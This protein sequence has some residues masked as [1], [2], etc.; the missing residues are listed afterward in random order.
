MTDSFVSNV[1][2][3]SYVSNVYMSCLVSNVYMSI[4]N[5]RCVYELQTSGMMRNAFVSN[6]ENVIDH[7]E[8]LNQ[9]MEERF[10]AALAEVID[11]CSMGDDFQFHFFSKKT[12]GRNARKLLLSQGFKLL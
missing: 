8:I 10:D 7:K 6:C 2:M 3:S 4:V 5:I 12:S 1:Y 9:L 11:G